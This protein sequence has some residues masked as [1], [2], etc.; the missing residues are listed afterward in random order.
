M[1]VFQLVFGLVLLVS[2]FFSLQLL[3]G[4]KVI[5][6]NSSQSAS[7]KSGRGKCVILVPAHNEQGG[8]EKTI[9]S[10]QAQLQ[11]GDIILVVADNC[12]DNT[13]SVARTNHAYCVERQ[14][15]VY[16]GKGYALQYGIDYIKQ[17]DE[18]F[19]TVVVM[20]AD[21]L[22]EKD[23]LDL[24]L[25]ASQKDNSVAQAL[26]LMKSPNKDNT[27]LNISEFTWLIKNWV[28]PVGQKKLGISCHLHGSGMAFP[29]QMLNNYSLASSNIVEDLELGL[30][31][32]KGGDKI[33]FVENAV[34]TS[35]FPENEEGLDIQRKRWEHGHLSIIAKM[36]KTM[37]SGL[38]NRNFNLFFQALDAAIPPITMW[39]LFLGF[40]LIITFVYGFIYQF[41]WALAYI[42]NLG[43][44]ISSLILCWY[45]FGQKILTTAQLKGL[46][47]FILSKIGVYRSFVFNRERTWVRTKRDDE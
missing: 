16:V 8:I 36:P 10:A 9:V 5:S 18:T 3:L 33:I 47:P 22:F 24:L 17:I 15:D 41:T 21:C 7:I 40:M 32:V 25:H 31:I 29:T 43:I 37:L 45:T 14:N 46:L 20:D 26:Y 38:I 2:F 30:N 13:A 39:V 12:S 4:L 6:Q 42:V 23:S 28:R 44:F 11:T 27:K 34:V 19:E 1:I 35:Y